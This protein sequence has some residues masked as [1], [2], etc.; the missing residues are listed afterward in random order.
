M[1]TTKKIIP[2]PEQDIDDNIEYKTQHKQVKKEKVKSDDYIDITDIAAVKKSLN[3]EFYKKYDETIEKNKISEYI[4]SDSDFND[5][6]KTDTKVLD[7]SNGFFMNFKKNIIEAHIS[8]LNKIKKRRD[9]LKRM[10]ELKTSVIKQ[11]NQINQSRIE[12][13]KYNLKTIFSK[14]KPYLID[15]ELR[16]GHYT[17]FIVFI[18]DDKFIYKDGTYII[19]DDLKFLDES[20]GLFCLSY[21]QDLVLP[22]ARK[23]FVNEIKTSIEMTGVSEVEA[24]VNP[25][26]LERFIKSEVIQ[27]VLKGAEMD[28]IFRFL[29]M[30]AILSFIGI[31]VVIL[32]L[33][34]TTGI[35]EKMKFW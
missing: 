12:I 6:I 19:D 32:I 10:T 8:R 3:P 11:Y 15:M 31:V 26:T 14:G 1:R 23:I 22:V 33:L 29:K 25:L 4:K 7:E 17:R 9:I 20:S 30:M 18:K 24:A 21:H 16:N 5:K 13:L 2:D 28:E 34:K 35:M 27:K